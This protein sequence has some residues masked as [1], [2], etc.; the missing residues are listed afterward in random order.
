MSLL[1][2][3]MDQAFAKLTPEERMALLQGTVEK[4]LMTLTPDERRQLL[5]QVVE[6]FLDGL[7]SEQQAALVRDVLPALL[8]RL[9]QAGNMSVDDFLWAAMG[10]LH[11]LEGKSRPA[12]GATDG[13]AAP[14]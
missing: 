14:D 3:L 2:N 9:L 7:S 11:A 4:A 8:G 12:A 10:S 6:R 1:E 5:D 13:A